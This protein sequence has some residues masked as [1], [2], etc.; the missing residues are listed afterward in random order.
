MLQY[1]CAV[2]ILAHIS[3]AA[4]IRKARPDLLATLDSPQYSEIPLEA[5]RNLNSEDPQIV[6]IGKPSNACFFTNASIDPT[7]W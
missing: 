4:T 7:N 5:P 2:L 1:L 6:D 3:L